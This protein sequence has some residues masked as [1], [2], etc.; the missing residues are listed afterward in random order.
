MKEKHPQLNEKRKGI[1]YTMIDGPLQ[2]LN[3]AYP[4][5]E[6]QEEDSTLPWKKIF[7]KSYMVDMVCVD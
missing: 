6:L 1:Q 4:H 5:L 2:L 3:F 7:K